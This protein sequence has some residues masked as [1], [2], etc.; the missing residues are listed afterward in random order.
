MNFKFSPENI[1]FGDRMGIVASFLGYG[2]I[3]P[4][5]AI[6]FIIAKPP[7]SRQVFESH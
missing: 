1:L 3:N 6:V 4:L 7:L 2:H 5:D